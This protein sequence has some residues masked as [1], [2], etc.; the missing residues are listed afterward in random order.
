VGSASIYPR[1]FP[2][3]IAII[4]DGNGR[5]AKARRRPRVFGH[6]Q[7]VETVRR[8]VEDA[9][10]M[11]VKCLTLYSFSTE[12]WTRPKSEINA[13]FNLLKQ[14]V[15]TDLAKLHENDVRIKILGSRSGLTDDLLALIDRV[16]TTT[17]KN[18]EFSLNIAF[19]YGGRDEIVRAVSRAARDGADL[20]NM[21]EVEFE[22]HLDSSGLP[23]PDLVIRTSGERRISNFL[24]WQAAY[25]E[26]VF[27]DV[28]WP[29]FSREDLSRAIAEYRSR[30][31]RF[32]SVDLSDVTTSEVA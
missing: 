26:F 13:L 11:G 25:A 10:K 6:Q 30:D 23:D 28:L 21:T 18:T 29:D 3:H 24:L 2:A 9:S 5:W 12:N 22:K 1:D 32:G 27:T 16:E 31:R 8:I 15:E 17:Q 14:Y 20:A 19:N 4:M 7:G